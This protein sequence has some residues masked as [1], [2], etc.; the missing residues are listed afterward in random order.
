VL[1]RLAAGI[2]VVVAMGTVSPVFAGRERELE[3]LAGAFTA[4]V[5]ATPA[6]VLLGGE[7]GGGKS[8]L[9]AEFAA[10]VSGRALLLTGGCVE[11]SGPGLPYA[12]FAAAVRG[13]VRERGTEEVAAL[14]PGQSAGELATLLPGF[15]APP[16]PA[17]PETARARLFEL[18]LVLLEALADQQTVVLIIEDVHWA[19][20]PTRDMLSFLARNLRDAAVLVVVT[21]R[22]DGLHHDDPL[23]RLLAGL[24][25]AGGV[26]RLE[27]ARLSRDQVAA[28]I[29]G[30]LGRPP[31]PSIVNAV[32]ERGGGN[33][34]FT[35]ALVNP[36]GT[37]RPDLPWTLLDLLLAT[38]KDLPEQAQQVLRTAAVGGHRIGHA[39]LTAV[40]GSD[41][42][43]L[44]AGLRP[45]VA[46]N[47]LVS[48]ADGYAFRHELIREAV[49]GDLLPGELA[50]A[51]HRFAEA[52]EAAPSLS[53]DGAAAVQVAQHWLGARDVERA[54]TAAWRAAADAGASFAYAEQLMMTEQVLR[55]WDQVPDPARH[56]GS[57]HVSVLMVAA[58][59]AHWAGE[60]ERG[61]ALVE[62]ALAEAGG[63]GGAGGAGKQASLLLRRAGLRR[64]LLLPGQLDDLWTA[65]RLAGG[66][67]R[68]RAHVIAQLCWALRR[69]DRHAEAEQFAKELQPL[70][71]QLGDDECQAEAMILQ[72]AIGAQKGEDNLDELWGGRDKAASIG[73]GH[74]EVWAYLTAAHVLEGHGHHER[75]IAAGRDGL[76]RARQLGLARQVAAPI[77]GKLAESLTSAGRWD[78]ALEIL[79]E[80]LSLD[81]P[82]LGRAHP[83]LVR[84]Q[85]AAARGDLETAEHTL[86]EL[87][88]LPA[89]LHAEAQYALSLARLQIN[90][91]LAA[92]DL[93]GAVAAA[94]EFPRYNPEADP[95]YP[96]ALLAAAMRA[97]AEA[98]ALSLPPGADDRAELRDDLESRAAR[99][100]RL[101]PLHNAYAALFAAEAARAGGRPD[102]AAWDAATAAWEEV[103][104]PYPLAYALALAAGSA[105][106]GDRS[107]A[108][109]RLRRAAALAGQL[110]AQPLQHQIS[111]LARRARIQLPSL[112]RG[113]AT[114]GAPVPFGLTA[115]EQEV[116]RLVAAGRGNREIAAELFISHRTASVHV[117]NIL[118]K[119]GV[120]SRGEA[121]ATAHR[122]HLF[123]QP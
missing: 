43:A 42:Q 17:D 27:L 40:T 38:V 87:R 58:D 36:D 61:L 85:I 64:E 35:E 76:A 44:T 96:W 118:G 31:A 50:Q 94:R 71:G 4:A 30:V 56:T 79:D 49:L 6:F 25:R 69:E 8:R 91:R 11:L 108:A 106:A 28:Q 101:S 111:Q 47:V 83:L 15:G 23:R 32:H 20:Q 19:D 9:A 65:V 105:A 110:C 73:S 33:P 24:E 34:L 72:A 66:P 107:A 60:P 54:M 97:C 5:G 63:A 99:V 3:V 7:A 18:V 67:T 117:S 52:L 121:A 10:R 112:D 62:A 123:D 41:D 86:Q 78:E 2:L 100:S 103:G 70:A 48:D 84:G 119:L 45:A 98:R 13:L 51:H 89:G 90:L 16:V 12:P 82:P 104:Q 93:T 29:E 109:S 53:P 116:L 120:S 81:Q 88:T 57:D 114:A 14:L 59:A 1:D 68:V 39:L 55:L 115:R 113:Q 92:G 22:S 102:L 26:T 46:A 80:I 77:A 75:A 37:V 21:F 95:R 74:L 122:L